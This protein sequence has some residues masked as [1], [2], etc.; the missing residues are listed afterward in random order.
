MNNKMETKLIHQETENIIKN[1]TRIGNMLVDGYHELLPQEKWLYVCL[2]RLC[3]AEGTRFLSL[4]YI[5]ERTGFS[6]GALSSSKKTGSPGML[7]RLHQAGLIHVEIKKMVGAGGKEMRQAQFHVTITDVWQKN[8]EFF[9]SPKCSE[10]E[11][12]IEEDRESV[13]KSNSKCSEVELKTAQSVRK[14][15]Q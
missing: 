11:Q 15:E 9:Y 14:S 2:I 8:Y 12:S 10:V 7:W 13:R 3:G 5:S 4:R 1:F 6:M